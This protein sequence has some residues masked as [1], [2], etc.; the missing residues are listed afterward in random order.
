MMKSPLN[1]ALI[2]NYPPDGQY[3]MQRFADLLEGGM[4]ELG[5]N[6]TRIEP[7]RILGGKGALSKWRGYVDKFVLFPRHA[8]HE[9]QQLA[10]IGDKVIVHICD[11]SNAPYLQLC[12]GL[13]TLITC[14]DVMA[15]KSGLGLVPQNPTRLSGRL[16][17]KWIFRHLKDAPFTACV[18]EKT[19]HDLQTLSGLP[20]ERLTVIPNALPFPFSP[21]PTDEAERLTP[22]TKGPFY[23]HVGSNAWYKNRVG[24]FALYRALLRSQPEARMVFVG[25]PDP[26]LRQAIDKHFLR[27]RVSFLTGLS[28]EQLAA[29]YSRAECLLFPSW[30][31]GFGWPIAEAQAC[32]CP[33]AILDRPP[34][35]EVGGSAAISLPGPSTNPKKTDEWAQRCAPLILDAL[36][37]R[38]ELKTNGIEQVRKYTPTRMIHA[39]H[40]LYQQ[41]TQAPLKQ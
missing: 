12:E 27:A 5:V 23:L 41:L 35:S 39:Y 36:K 7:K 3:S 26:A 20:D 16:L 14:H 22:D 37:R 34:M 24:A 11:H 17:Q 9:L 2:A 15:I 30:E 31:E 8:R 21:V 33:V 18:S 38:E 19:R 32:G 1:L 25:P 29:L 10:S 6:V 40:E 13:P 28:N 4:R